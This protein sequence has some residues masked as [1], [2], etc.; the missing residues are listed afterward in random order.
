MD[1]YK[2]YIIKNDINEKV[3]IGSTVNTLAFRFR[4]HCN[5]IGSELDRD[6]KK[7]GK[8]HFSIE[9]LSEGISNIEKVDDIENYYID[10]FDSIKSG[11]NDRYA[12]S[13]F[14]RQKS[15][16]FIDLT[17]KRF[18]RLLVIK[19]IGRCSTGITWLCKCD[20]GNEIV[21]PG[22]AIRNGNTKSCGCLQREVAALRCKSRAVHGMYKERLY[23][24][25]K[26]MKK[27]C[28][29]QNDSAYK[30]YGGRGIIV[31]DEWKNDY[32]SFRNWAYAN[33]YDENATKGQC[34]LD[35]IDV[36]GNYEPSN[37]RW[38]NALVQRHNRRPDS[39]PYK[40]R[41]AES[42]DWH[43]KRVVCVETGTIFNSVGDA[44]KSVGVALTN[45]SACC[46]G[47]LDT[48]KGFHWKYESTSDKDY[49]ETR[50]RF[51][52]K[53]RFHGGKPKKKVLQVETG[54]VF[55]SMADAAKSVGLK[56]HSSIY[57]C[58]V[59]KCKT[60]AGYHW[61]LIRQSGDG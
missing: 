24:V 9:L 29:N 51:D 40:R 30:N 28:Y 34:T 22:S 25:W 10:L 31:C 6:I 43:R 23:K 13:S 3:Y 42:Y 61:D 50:D 16:N 46:N 56:S 18:D 15:S 36:N 12:Y 58:I 2:V 52:N 14:T 1:N 53:I 49:K 48:I 55:D 7:Y 20:C 17:G 45:I 11:Y 35:R 60:A 44:A 8:E 26:S 57:D 5:G 54:K 38:A 37:C 4:Q 32:L 39:K 33:G 27:R 21:V 59:G 47:R 19:R 41:S